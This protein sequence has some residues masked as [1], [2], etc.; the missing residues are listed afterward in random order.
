MVLNAIS[1]LFQVYCG[2]QYIYPC[3]LGVL[4]T[5]ALH[6]NLSK[7]TGCFPTYTVETMD[8]SERGMNHVKMTIINPWKEYWPSPGA[9]QGPMDKLI[10]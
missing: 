2:D 10:D 4:L 5:S 7:A 6:N 3:F 8:S 1:T 9:N